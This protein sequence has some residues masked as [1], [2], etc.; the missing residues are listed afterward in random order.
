MY[1]TRI[2]E[3]ISAMGELHGSTCCL[4]LQTN[5]TS[6][7]LRPEARVIMANLYRRFFFKQLRK[8]IV[9]FCRLVTVTFVTQML[10]PYGHFIRLFWKLLSGELQLIKCHFIVY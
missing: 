1:R 5:L 7:D 6:Y 10:I 4:Q 8:L 2:R 9:I 3:I